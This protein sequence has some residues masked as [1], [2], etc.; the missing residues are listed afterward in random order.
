MSDKTITRITNK[1]IKKHGS[2]FLYFIEVLL[3]VFVA[4]FI[5]ITFR[6]EI[7]QGT[8]MSPA[9]EPGDVALCMKGS[10]NV[11]IGDIIVF[12]TTDGLHFMKRVIA[13]EGQ[14]VRLDPA[15]G[16][17][18]VDGVLLQDGY[19]APRQ[20]EGW[21]EFE[22]WPGGY[23]GAATTVP[24]GCFFC[25]GDNRAESIDSRDASVGMVSKENIWGKMIWQMPKTQ[26]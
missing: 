1:E 6:L 2:G 8:S 14:T 12:Q 13:K 23:S 17:I 11:T 9:L 7:I 5:L 24:E 3:A 25:L 4:A 22:S 15:T 10:E 16:D 26:K 19:A 21:T 18:Y 20:S